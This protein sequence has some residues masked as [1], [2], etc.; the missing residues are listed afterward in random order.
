VKHK[1]NTVF[2][3]NKFFGFLNKKNIAGLTKD[4]LVVF[5]SELV[6]ETDKKFLLEFQN[7]NDVFDFYNTAK[8]HSSAVFTYFP[9]KEK[10]NRVP[11]FEKEDD[12]YQKESLIRLSEKRG[13]SCLGTPR[14]FNKKNIPT[15]L[16]RN[17]KVL[18]FSIGETL[19]Q[20]SFVEFLLSLEHE[21]VD[22]VEQ[23]S[24]FS[25]KGDVVDFFP[26]HQK[27]PIRVSFEFNKVDNICSFDPRSQL[28][29]QKLN[30]VYVQG[31]KKTQVSDNINLID[32]CPAALLVSVKINNALFSLSFNNEKQKKN[33][34]FCTYF[35]PKKTTK[36]NQ[37]DINKTLNGFKNVFFISQTKKAPVVFQ[38]VQPNFIYGS[39]EKSFFSKKLGVFFLSE[40]DFLG[41][42]SQKNRWEPSRSNNVF[43]FSKTSVSQLTKGDLVVHKSFGV[44]SYLGPI[45]KRSK[46]GVIEGVELEYKNNTKVFVSMENLDLIHRY[47]GTGKKPSLSTLGSKKWL[48]EIKKTRTSVKVVAYEIFSLYS[49]KL[50]KRNFNYVKEND[51]GNALSSSFSFLE[52]PDQKKAIL[53]VYRDMNKN[54]PM[55]RLICGDVGFGK[56]E[57]AIRAIF[58]A[59]LSNKT[60]VL[61]C[62]T[63]ILADQHFITCNERLSPFGVRVSLLSRFKSKTEQTKTILQL[64]KGKTDVLIGTHRVLSK[65]V[66]IKNLGLLIIDE[67]HRFGVKHKEKIR[68]IKNN[69]DV[70]TLTATPIPR[71]LQQS[72]VGIRNLS[73]IK[74]PP[75]SRKPITTFVK[76][77]NWDLIYN[78]IKRELNRKGQ[79]YFLNNDIKT[80]PII[81]KKLK[82]RFK[83]QTIEGASGKMSS[84]HLEE[85]VLAF[86]DGKIDILV[87]TTIIESG[88]DV[89]NANTLIVNNAQNFGLA[90]LY[91]IR[92]RVGRGEKQAE[93]LLLIPQKKELDVSSYNRLKAIEK[94]TALG[95]GY[96]I[97]QKDLEIRGSGSLFGYK[98][99]GHISTVGFEMY[100]ELLKEEVETLKKGKQNK[101]PPL[102]IISEK[103]EL[104]SSYIKREQMRIDYYYQLSKASSIK[105]IKKIENNLNDAFG[106]PPKETIVLINTVKVKTMLL[107]SL[108]SK[109]EASNET[110]SLFFKNQNL[111]FDI[112]AFFKTVKNFKHKRLVSY[113]YENNKD[114]DLIIRFKTKKFFPSM[115]LLFSF[116]KL[117]K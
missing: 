48:G 34:G 110:L 62:P 31:F 85:V 80:I 94:N 18:S 105:E 69:V 36:N 19:N 6:L 24:S 53:D 58:K 108:I 100:C 44:G 72:L 4:A 33:L 109:I 83:S 89:T 70:L 39:I 99:S 50:Q 32:Y 115:S 97:S 102:L 38:N 20:E 96:N 113:K 12:R 93:C 75:L 54:K 30:R 61:L 27:N 74:T 17:K 46:I 22:M 7:D 35:F 60:S 116:I 101:K 15:G 49:K 41:T 13:V 71:T 8:E 9:L 78:R 84:K 21:K 95:S 107:G 82:Q 86:F 16:A 37:F 103:A 47:V 68:S 76:Y 5:L 3:K 11:G 112:D 26:K 106:P 66:F 90:Q 56:T 25:Q 98:Q 59:C 87:C 64:K 51:I 67:E 81:V 92:G 10:E 40:N 2:K 28:S 43:N 52:T 77:F 1:Q 79:I 14:S 42:Y 29:L 117:I 23:P 73:T 91:Q 88:L 45:E 55:D 65:D 111:D 57:V 114:F 104:S 63:T